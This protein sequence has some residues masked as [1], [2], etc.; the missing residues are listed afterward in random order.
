MVIWLGGVLY[1]KHLML[2]LAFY[3]MERIP[4]RFRQLLSGSRR[5]CPVSVCFLMNFL[6]IP[7]PYDCCCYRPVY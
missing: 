4:Y 7:S 2:R 1:L 3:Y 6:F 5:F